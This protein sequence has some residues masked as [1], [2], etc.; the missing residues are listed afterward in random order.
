M[1]TEAAV[2]VI[3]GVIPVDLLAQGRNFVHQSKGTLG[4][5]RSRQLERDQELRASKG[6]WMEDTR[7]SWTA[8]L[9]G[10]MSPWFHRRHGEVDYY[11]TQMLTG[12]GLFRSYLHKIGKVGDPKCLYCGDPKDDA[13]HTFSVVRGG[14]RS[15]MMWTLPWGRYRLTASLASCSRAGKIGR[16]SLASSGMSNGRKSRTYRMRPANRRTE[17]RRRGRG[18]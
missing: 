5:T 15:A 10:E 1:V 7:G 8:K 16:R 12:H 18:C 17:A 3:A 9:I 6:H 4:H 11:F 14:R 2:L 13:L